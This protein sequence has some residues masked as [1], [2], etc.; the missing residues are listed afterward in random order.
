MTVVLALA[1]RTVSGALAADVAWTAQDLAAVADAATSDISEIKEKTT[2]SNKLVELA[3]ALS[4]A[5][6]TGRARELLVKSLAMLGS[7]PDLT[8]LHHDIVS[9]LVRVRDDAAAEALVNEGP[10]EKKTSLL[11][12]LGTSRA[13]AHDIE[14]AVKAARMIASLSPSVGP[15][16]SEDPGPAVQRISVALIRAGAIDQALRISD[17]MKDRVA[18]LPIVARATTTL[19]NEERTDK[20]R[21]LADR[22][23]AEARAVVKTVDKPFQIIA[24][25]AAAA[26]A[27]TACGGTASAMAFVISAIPSQ[28]PD[29][30]RSAVADLLAASGQIDLALVLAPPEPDDANGFFERSKLLKKS[31][32]LKAAASAALEASRI[33]IEGR[34]NSPKGGIPLGDFVHL[35]A[36]LGAYDAA[37][38]LAETGYWSADNDW[39]RADRKANYARIVGAAIDHK[40]QANVT[41]LTPIALKAFGSPTGN[42]QPPVLLLEDLVRRLALGG[43]REEARPVFER[44]LSLSQDAAAS[45]ANR[46]PPQRMAALK[47]AMGDLS[48]AL[49]YVGDAGPMTVA[50]SG[51]QILALTAM[52]FGNPSAKPSPEEIAAAMERA[53]TALP[54][55]LAGPKAKALSEVARELATLGDIAGALQIVELLDVEPRHVLALERDQTLSWIARAQTKTGDLR[56]ALATTLKMTQGFSRLDSLIMLAGKRPS[57]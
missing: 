32:D 41:R 17:G 45:P 7:P 30:T 22:T 10:A 43:Y 54:P 25:I 55:Q 40:D 13:E 15:P 36:D 5:G 48:G 23:V 28:I 34:I 52:Q 46:V 2:Q 12:E 27:E 4:K 53:K 1:A 19:C 24:T 21:D 56:G 8:Y 42:G 11:R 51:L 38:A 20:A 26:E 35:L 57:S 37:I 47:A 6:A 49:K 50:P 14:G 18:A 16:K 31:G 39:I 9:D 33:I 44:L 3:E 29:V